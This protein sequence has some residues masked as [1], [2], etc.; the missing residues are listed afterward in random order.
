MFEL[1]ALI[2]RKKLHKDIITFH[3]SKQLV[4]QDVFIS[5]QLVSSRKHLVVS[6]IVFDE[7]YVRRSHQHNFA[8]NTYWQITDKPTCQPLIESVV[9]HVTL[10]KPCFHLLL[11]IT[12]TGNH[13]CPKL[14]I[15]I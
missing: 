8:D 14:Q 13:I 5:I 4:F 3:H 15:W 10:D 6:T 12:I 9:A 1:P 2:G 7:V 11:D